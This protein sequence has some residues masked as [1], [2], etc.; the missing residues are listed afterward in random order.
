MIRATITARDLA[1][2]MRAVAPHCHDKSAPSLNCII[3]EAHEG[4]LI[5]T[6][7]DRSVV[8][9]LRL[10]PVEPPSPDFRAWVPLRAMKRAADVFHATRRHC[11]DLL[12]EVDGDRLAI[13]T[14]TLGGPVSGA[15][16]VVSLGPPDESTLRLIRS[17]IRAAHTATPAAAVVSLDVA[18]LARFVGAQE[19]GESVVM[20]S[21]GGEPNYFGKQKPLAVS[22]GDDFR[23]VAQP[24]RR[25]RGADLDADA[26]W[27]WAVAP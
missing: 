12:L 21:T 19:R 25:D 22:V 15:S 26:A 4:C 27:A 11:P 17:I 20:W 3:L 24:A 5:A 8:A 9:S 6:A 23:A 18:L 16:I 10:H 14:D 13:A 2:I 1:R 7:T